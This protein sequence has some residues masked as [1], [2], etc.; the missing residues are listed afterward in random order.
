MDRTSRE[1]ELIDHA[2]S[3]N[4]QAI[5]ELV[6]L[7]GPRVRRFASRLCPSIEALDAAQEALL[8]L[9]TQIGALKSSQAL[10]SWC[11]QVVKRQCGKVFSRMTRESALAW[12]LGVLGEHEDVPDREM[13]LAD[14][15]RVLA[16][17][18]PQ[19]R[20]ILVLR[21]LQE[22]SI[23]DSA[24]HLKISEAAVKSRLHRARVL[25][26]QHMLERYQHL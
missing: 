21:D 1:E 15:G 5:A 14:L 23:K 13:L 19:D 7:W 18:P 9:A 10:A 6:T 16:V 22:V 11:F 25:L 17:L 20:K 2:R 24:A 8:I 26:R 4:P 3:G 12:D